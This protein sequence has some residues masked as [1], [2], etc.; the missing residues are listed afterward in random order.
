MNGIQWLF[1]TLAALNCFGG[2]SGGLVIDW[3]LCLDRANGF[4]T[5]VI[6]DSTV[7][8]LLTKLG[9]RPSFLL[10]FLLNS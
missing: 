2:A 8:F 5:V 4:G 7:E 6:L 9:F 3:P 10:L 1:G